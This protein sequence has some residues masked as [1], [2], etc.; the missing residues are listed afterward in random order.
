MM[1]I[2]KIPTMDGK[3]MNNSTL[4][5][6]DQLRS[7]VTSLI[8]I[9]A[10]F[11]LGMT[12]ANAAF[13]TG[14]MGIGGGYSASGGTDLS[15]ATFLEL[16]SVTGT[17]GTDI[18]GTSVGFFTPGIVNNGSFTINPFTPPQTNL[19]VIGGWQLDLSSLNIVDQTAGILSMNGSGVLSGNGYQDTN[20]IWTFSAQS[21]GSTYSMTITAIPVPAAV[22]LFCAGLIGLVAI[23]RRKR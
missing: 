23:A 12:A 3:I 22:W 11:L 7:A 18:L 5:Y 14:N 8:Q 13:I 1:K 2:H 20:A 21:T 4:Y 6:L 19:F 17:S 10:L 16:T 9:S 15:D